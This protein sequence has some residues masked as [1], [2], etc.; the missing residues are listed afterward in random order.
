MSILFFELENHIEE[1]TG[2]DYIE[3]N[4]QNCDVAPRNHSALA[5]RIIGNGIIEYN[6]NVV[7]FDSNDVLYLPQ[8]IGY[9]AEYSD[10]KLIVIHFIT[11]KSDKNAEVFSFQN[12]EKIYKLFLDALNIWQNKNIG[13]KIS[14][15]SVLYKI[16]ATIYK[17]TQKISLPKNF[18][19]AISL[20]NSC[21]KENTISIKQICSEA[22]IS[23][24]YFRKLFAENYKKT[25]ITYINELRI[26]YARNLISS[27]ISI[28]KAAYESGFN[29]PKYF[30][31]TV[32]KYFDCTPREL[33]LFGK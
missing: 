4:K 20:I 2:V 27:G 33:K 21:Y 18:I 32:K 6:K 8:K 5:F 29:D 7:C 12:T 13:Y 15:L 17:E 24:T 10:T 26:E 11:S 19:R 28:E 31:R 30:A 14:T 25:P 23:E 1:I 3:W 22:Q 9:T 16:L